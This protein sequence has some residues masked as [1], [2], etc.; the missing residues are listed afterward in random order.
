MLVYQVLSKP[1]CGRAILRLFAGFG[2]TSWFCEFPPFSSV[3]FVSVDDGESNGDVTEFEPGVLPS[4]G[5]PPC[6]LVTGL[7]IVK[8][9]VVTFFG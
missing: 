4:V 1:M 5:S 8:I 2:L 6:N 3:T 7:K 9:Y